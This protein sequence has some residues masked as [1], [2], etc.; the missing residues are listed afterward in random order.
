MRVHPNQLRQG[1]LSI[2][3]PDSTTYTGAIETAEQFGKRIYLEA[4]QRGWENAAKKV[5]LADGA[6]WIWNLADLHLPCAIQIFD[7]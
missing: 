5:V 2:R 4:Y 7:L 1:G 6:E 3:D